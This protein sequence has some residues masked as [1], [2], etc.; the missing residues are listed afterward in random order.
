MNKSTN[1]FKTTVF[2]FFG[3]L[4]FFSQTPFID[5]FVHFYDNF[6]INKRPFAPNILLYIEM[7]EK[8]KINDL[9]LLRE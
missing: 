3:N 5:D 6:M 4:F 7:Y 8:K 2:F 9:N 1:Y